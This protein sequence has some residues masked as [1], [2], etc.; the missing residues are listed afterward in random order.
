V[1]LDYS[2][3]SHSQ[4]AL[5]KNADRADSDQSLSRTDAREL[6]PQPL[7]GRH[8]LSQNVKATPKR[9][10]QQLAKGESDVLSHILISD[11]III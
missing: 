5:D 8:Y 3:S 10:R 6:L 9:L 2:G 7:C 4:F 11:T 1:S